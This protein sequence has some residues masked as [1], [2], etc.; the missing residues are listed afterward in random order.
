MAAALK[1]LHRARRAGCLDAGCYLNAAKIVVAS[2]PPLPYAADSTPAQGGVTASM[3]LNLLQA[4]L[5]YKLDGVG[6]LSG[7]GPASYNPLVLSDALSACLALLQREALVG[8][9]ARPLSFPSSSALSHLHALLLAAPAHLLTPAVVDRVVSQLWQLSSGW[10]GAGD[11][12]ALLTD[13]ML[14][15]FRL[16]S[17]EGGEGGL[18]TSRVHAAKVVGAAVSG[19]GEGVS[20]ATAVHLVGAY[21]LPFPS[22]AN[23]VERRVTLPA[24]AFHPLLRRILS[25]SAQPHA[26]AWVVLTAC[27]GASRETTGDD[28]RELMGLGVGVVR[29]DAVAP[30]TFAIAEFVRISRVPV[31]A[32]LDA[33]V[34]GSR[35]PDCLLAYASLSWWINFTSPDRCQLPSGVIR[36]CLSLL[37]A[38]GRRDLALVLYQKL[39][40]QKRL[41]HWAVEPSSVDTESVREWVMDLH[42][43][44]K[45]MAV[46]AV[47]VALAEVAER[48]GPAGPS[49]EGEGVD[50]LVVITGQGINRPLRR[51][52]GP[53]VGGTFVLVDE[54]QRL[55]IENYL[56]PI[57]STTVPGNPGRLR[58]WVRDILLASTRASEPKEAEADGPGKT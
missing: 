3:A 31:A 50:S 53:T 32:N 37:F 56:P 18:H 47:S 23:G 30:T 51:S 2:L 29:G 34:V 36:D 9:R 25:F 24:S 8:Q 42:E 54:I 20:L 1:L 45:G 5:G 6:V 52:E 55:L 14:G 17:A 49:T 40:R 4:G 27:S 38:G 13:L 35:A 15:P 12:L 43:Y 28:G 26:D 19:G 58:I 33:S 22:G 39:Y 57:A 44:S 41:L 7:P 21:C 16:V 10:T 48:Y 11:V 46:A